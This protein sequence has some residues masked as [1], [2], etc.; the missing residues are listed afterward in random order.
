MR[1]LQD[2][3][4]RRTLQLPHAFCSS[5]E[6]RCL[7]VWPGQ[8]MTMQSKRPIQTFYVQGNL[9]SGFQAVVQC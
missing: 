2:E 7:S 5:P 1:R 3:L 6:L 9:L 8:A 4:H